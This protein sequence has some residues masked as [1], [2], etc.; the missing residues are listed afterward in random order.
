MPRQGRAVSFALSFVAYLLGA[1]YIFG[2]GK[3]GWELQRAAFGA[4]NG[5]EPD[6]ECT[7]MI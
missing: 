4:D 2:T 1:L 6:C 5:R 3:G 7:A